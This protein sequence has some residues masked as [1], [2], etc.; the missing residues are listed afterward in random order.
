MINKNFTENVIVHGTSLYCTPRNRDQAIH[1]RKF[2]KDFKEFT[3]HDDKIQQW[4][5]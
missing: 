1:K 3:H 2:E 4:N 5:F